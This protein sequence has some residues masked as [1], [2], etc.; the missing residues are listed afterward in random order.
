MLWRFSDHLCG[1]A[2]FGLTITIFGSYCR[3]GHR[4]LSELFAVIAAAKCL[5]AT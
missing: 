3:G 2:L 4:V 1:L 5:Y